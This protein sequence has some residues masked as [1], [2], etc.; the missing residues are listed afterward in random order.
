MIRGFPPV[1]GTNAR[2]LIL[3]SMPGRVSL[4]ADEYY[5]QPRNVFWRIMGELFGAGAD[6]PY[7][8]R[9][10]IL[11]ANG[12]ALWDVLESCHRPG[13][14]DAS[15]DVKT[16]RPNDF[17][18]FFS[19]H[20]SIRRVLFNGGKAEDLYR[21]RVLPAAEQTAPTLVYARL[22]STSPAYAAMP[23][24]QKLA[25]WSTIKNPAG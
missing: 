25:R 11:M 3:G 8:E 24:E 23:Y 17:P 9:L 4:E 15:I 10:K 12:I 13:S 19:T 16:A 20:R 22:P 14:L 18:G 1:C 6:K 21:R 2:I 7:M 5:A